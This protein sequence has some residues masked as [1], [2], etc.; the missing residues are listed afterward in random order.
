MEIARF[1][2]LPLVQKWLGDS[3]R[4]S[5]VVFFC[6]LFPQA[7]SLNSRVA[8]NIIFCAHF[9]AGISRME[10]SSTLDVFFTP[11]PLSGLHPPPPPLSVFFFLQQHCLRPKKCKA[12]LTWFTFFPLFFCPALVSEVS[13][14]IFMDVRPRPP[15]PPRPQRI[16]TTFKMSIYEAFL[17]L[18]VLSSSVA[19]FFLLL[20]L[21]LFSFCVCVPGLMDRGAKWAVFLL[22]QQRGHLYSIP[23]SQVSHSAPLQ[24]M[25]GP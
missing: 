13:G 1:L 24:V 22:F 10:T 8:D 2:L 6:L 4:I 20:L 25:S 17:L 15:P 3:G 18:S 16:V 11:P 7:T 23:G 9:S 21:L 5:H 19:Y 14:L 12:A